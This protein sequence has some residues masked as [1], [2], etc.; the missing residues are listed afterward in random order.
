MEN[1]IRVNQLAEVIKGNVL[2]KVS[3]CK[4]LAERIMNFSL[5][6]VHEN[7]KLSLER[8]RD[9]L[10]KS[11]KGFYCTICNFENH[12]FFDVKNHKIFYSEKFCRDLV[13]NSLPSLLIYH[14]DVIK[15]LNIATKMVV[16][17]DFR[18]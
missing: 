15:L 17:C 8:M 18:G 14:I 7:I 3:N 11:Y 5:N 2:A 13:E 4:F 10:I 9:F 12:K 1:L 6:T 16:H